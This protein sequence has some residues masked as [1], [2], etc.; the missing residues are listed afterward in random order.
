M[1][2]NLN[3]FRAQPIFE[4]LAHVAQTEIGYLHFCHFDK[5]EC[6]EELIASD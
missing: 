6:V 2:A 4:G 3:V 1:V 5:Y